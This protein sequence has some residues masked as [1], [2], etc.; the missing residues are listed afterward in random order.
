MIRKRNFKLN[1]KYALGEVLLIFIGITSAIW[2]QNWN[3]ERKDKIKVN[4]YLATIANNL[5][6]DSLEISRFIQVSVEKTAAGEKYIQAV[7]VKKPSL[8]A[9]MAGLTQLEEE[10]LT[11]NSNGFE[12]LKASGFLS[13]IQGGQIEKALFDYYSY[14]E[15][16]HED[17]SSMNQFIEAQELEFVKSAATTEFMIM[18]TD[19]YTNKREAVLNRQ[20]QQILA[21]V[22]DHPSLISVNLR[23]GFID[24]SYRELMEMGNKLKSLINERLKR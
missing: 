4:S 20:E 22:Y 6:S 23:A 15:E 3:E 12:S 2:F 18:V 19:I 10:Y 5:S 8:E 24:S 21:L 11:L 9:L 16:I 1:W 7:R 13:N 14:Y 17:E